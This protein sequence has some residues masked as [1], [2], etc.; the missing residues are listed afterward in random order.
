M[1]D[2]IGKGFLQFA[3][4]LPDEPQLRLR[5]D[6]QSSRILVNDDV[7]QRERLANRLLNTV[8]DGVCL[9]QREVRIEFEV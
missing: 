4:V 7:R 9:T 1:L 6:T 2:H 8:A 3:K 5:R